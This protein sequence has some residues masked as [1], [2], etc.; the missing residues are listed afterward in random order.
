MPN[1]WLLT[2]CFA[3]SLALHVACFVLP[4]FRYSSVVPDASKG[5]IVARI[6]GSLIPPAMPP[7]LPAD[8]GLV[9]YEAVTGSEG[10]AP[11]ASVDSDK[12]VAANVESEPVV[13]LSMDDYLPPSLL[14]RVPKPIGVVD[15]T[16][17]FRG[18]VGVVGQAEILLLISSD[19]DVDDVLM[20]GS[21][22]P[23][24]LVEEAM[25]RFRRLKFEPGMLR[26]VNVRSRLRIRLEPP[27]SDELLGNPSS[28][29]ERAWRR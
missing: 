2:F 7:Q 20:L 19:G 9:S 22:L 1:L 3:L 6:Y 16:I 12:A 10:G 21:S 4:G 29:R 14:D 28:A 13:S 26:S 18:M 25:L 5:L 17:G 11:V 15:T 8:S 23:Q 24:F 27:G